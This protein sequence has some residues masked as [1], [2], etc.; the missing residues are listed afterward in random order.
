[1]KWTLGQLAK[2][3]KPI[4]VSYELDLKEHLD[5]MTDCKDIDIV[6]V[7]VT[8]YETSFDEYVFSLD[9]T[10]TL[11]MQCAVTLED[12]LYPL[13]VHADEVFSTTNEDGDDVN[14]VINNMVDLD[15]VVLATIIMSIPMKVV[16]PGAEDLFASEDSFNKDDKVNPAFAD[17]EEYLK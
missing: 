14:L 9:I 13:N 11:T 2:M 10:T 1:M 16:K 15:P 3:P 4:M 8:G 17:L 5:K 7:N 12:I 6:K